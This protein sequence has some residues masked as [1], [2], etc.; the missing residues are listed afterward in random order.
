MKARARSGVTLALAAA[1]LALGLACPRPAHAQNVGGSWSTNQGGQYSGPAFPAPAPPRSGR[2]PNAS[3]LELGMLYGTSVAYGV[4]IGV[5][6]DTEIGITDP[7]VAL[8]PPAILGAAAPVG[9][10]FLDDAPR[11]KRGEPAAIALGAAAGA[12]EGLG[13]AGYQITTASEGNEWDFRGVARSVS[14]GATLGAVGGY[15]VAYY[16][17]PPPETSTFVGSGIVWGTAIGSMFGFGASGGDQKFA[18]SNDSAALG[19]LIG[20]NVGLIGTA[21]LGMVYVPSFESIGWMW[22]GAGIGAAASLPVFLFYIG[23]S[24][25]PAKRGFLFMGTATTLGLALGGFFGGE[26]ADDLRGQADEPP[27]GTPGGKLASIDFVAPL[28]LDSGGGVQLGGQF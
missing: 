24:Q 10:W 15:A 14:L 28:V 17:E 6:L 18:E 13:I 11:L 3:S 21:A 23:D 4:G 20:Y 26:V 9:V 22:A 16:A 25:P 2:R 7:G 12:G 5:W 8:I 27:V 19:G 1:A